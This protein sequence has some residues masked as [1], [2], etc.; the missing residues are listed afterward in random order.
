MKAVYKYTLGLNEIQEISFPVGAKILSVAEQR[1]KIVLY[2]L[3][4][5]DETRRIQRI[6]R[7]LGTGKEITHAFCLQF[8][9]T[10]SLHG[11]N[12][13]CHVFVQEEAGL[14]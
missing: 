11:G 9:G 4:D 5:P 6:V 8:V 2:A 3:V 12:L 13:M 10:V 14:L 1:G 7:I